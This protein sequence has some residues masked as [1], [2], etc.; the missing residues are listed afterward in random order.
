LAICA[1][2][3]CKPEIFSYENLLK[4]A[5]FGN[6]NQVLHS[7]FS[8]LDT[9]DFEAVSKVLDTT[10]R[11]LTLYSAENAII[12]QI[13]NDRDNIKNALISSISSTHPDNPTQIKN[14]EYIAARKFLSQF[15]QIFSV[16]YDLLIYWTRNQNLEPTSYETDDGFRGD[17]WEGYGTDQNV[18]FL[19]GGLHIYDDGENIRKHTYDKATTIIEKVRTCLDN[20]KFP[21]FISEPTYKKKKQKIEH[22]PYLN[23]C[24][25]SLKKLEGV[26]FIHG[27]S[28]NESDKHIFDQI[29]SNQKITT[30]FVSIYRDENNES[31]QRT[32]D[33]ARSFLTPK[34]KT[35]TRTVD[36]YDAKSTPVWSSV[37]NQ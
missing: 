37:E 3:P 9:Y 29:N 14:Q 12:Q 11:T 2:K 1:T 17:T 4:K 10:E 22:N 34:T 19:H 7:L 27:H 32:K 13:A 23:Y 20:G 31:N 21:L 16:N 8:D 26:L 6:R 18:H 15:D 30:V 33:H 5:T 24:F 36:F 28:M 35:T 25:Q